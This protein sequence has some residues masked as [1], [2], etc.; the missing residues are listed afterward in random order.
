MRPDR[1]FFSLRTFSPI[2]TG[3]VCLTPK[4]GRARSPLEES[5]MCHKRTLS[6]SYA[7]A[8]L[9]PPSYDLGSL[10]RQFIPI[11]LELLAGTSYVSWIE[12]LT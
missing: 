7:G 6:E 9:A 10:V 1:Y 4:S 3:S 12:V 2:S 11:E 5:A 8:K